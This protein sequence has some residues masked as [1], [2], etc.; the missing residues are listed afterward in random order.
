MLLILIF[1]PSEG[2]SEGRG[3][4]DAAQT[5]EEEREEEKEREAAAAGPGTESGH[6]PNTGRYDGPNGGHPRP[7]PAER[8]TAG[9]DGEASEDCHQN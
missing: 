3:R 4:S 2:V 9:P 6:E 7:A 1:F 8:N 5:R